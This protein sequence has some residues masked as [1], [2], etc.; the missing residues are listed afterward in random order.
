MMKRFC[1][2]SGRF[3]CFCW[4]HEFWKFLHV[5]VTQMEFI[6]ERDTRIQ[7]LFYP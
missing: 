5:D 2:L 7:V 4:L 3:C 1:L 6:A